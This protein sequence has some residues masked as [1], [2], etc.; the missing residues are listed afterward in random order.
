LDGTN[1]ME[2]KGDVT[3]I[4][5]VMDAL[6]IVLWEEAEPPC[7]G[8]QLLVGSLSPIMKDAK[9]LLQLRSD[10]RYLHKR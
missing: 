7:V 1:Y 2:R 10:Y 4:L 3:V 9:R 5:R 6:E 8:N